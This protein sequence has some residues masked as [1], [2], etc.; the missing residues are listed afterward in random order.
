VWLAFAA[1]ASGAYTVASV[2]IGVARRT[3]LLN[4]C[5]L[6][7][8]AAAAGANGLLTARWG[9]SGAAVATFLGYGA[10][11]LVTYRIAQRV[12]PLP[13]RGGRLIA[14][15]A[16]ALALALFA[17]TWTGQGAAGLVMK[18]AAVAAFALVCARLALWKERG[19]VAPS[20]THAAGSG[21][22]AG[23]RGGG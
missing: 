2:G 16:L 4:W 10:S 1:V 15:F 5:A 8:F 9:A 17:Q 14:V 12:H 11:A 18:I 23:E 6:A 22:G 7:A 20:W 19:G 21:P 13:Y 3:P